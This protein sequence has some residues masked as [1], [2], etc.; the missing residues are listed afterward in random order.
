M[1]F[2]SA[3]KGQKSF[4][5]SPIL[6]RFPLQFVSLNAVRISPHNYVTQNLSG[7]KFNKQHSPY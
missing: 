4:I 1:A 5:S 7:T 6:C 2:N 3:S